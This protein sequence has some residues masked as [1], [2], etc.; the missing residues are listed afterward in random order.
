MIETEQLKPEEDFYIVAASS[1]MAE[2]TRV[3]KQGESFAIFNEHGD[4]EKGGLGEQ[5]LYHQGTRHLSRLRLALG[6]NQPFLL[7]SS[8]GQDNLMLAV[9]M[10]NTDLFDGS[11]IRLPRGTI[12]VLAREFLWKASC[13]QHYLIRNHGL[14]P[15]ATDLSFLFEADFA[16]IFEVRGT[17]RQRRGELHQPV[18]ETDCVVLAYTGLD[19][20]IRR[21]LLHFHPVPTYLG[22][23]RARY[24]LE[25]SSNVKAEILVR[26]S[27]ETGQSKSRVFLSFENALSAIRDSF[28]AIR[29]NESTILTSNEQFNHSINRAATDLQLMVTETEYGPY[30]YAGIPW[31]NTP[32]GRDG[33]ITALQTLW[34]NPTLAKGVLRYLASNQATEVNEDRDA[35]PGKILHET[36]R[37]EMAALNEIPF[38]C[39]YGSVDSTPLFV[40]LAGRYYEHT[41]DRQFMQEIWPNIKGALN[42]IDEYGDRDHDGFVEYYRKTPKGLANQGWKDSFDSVFHAEGRL[43]EG[44]IAL[45][46][47]QCYVHAAK[48]AAARIAADLGEPELAGNLQRQASALRDRF[49]KQFWCEEIDTYALA[50][51]GDKR[52]CQVRTSNAGHA[53]FTGT[54]SPEHA[55][56]LAATLMAEDSFSGWGIRTVSSR[57][58]R[59]NPMSYHNGS[60]W[61]HDN[62]MI[63]YG[64]ARY[65]FTNEALRILAGLFDASLFLDLNRLPE[66]FCGFERRPEEGPTLYPVACAPQAW[67]SGA[68]FLILQGCLG[69]SVNG[70]QRTVRFDHPALPPFL[71]RVEITALPVGQAQIGLSVHEHPGDVGISILSRVGDPEVVIV[72]R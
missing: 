68:L 63:A 22:A 53:L 30:P 38:G 49:L 66:L 64:L 19:Q 61:P 55:T 50:L 42:W 60:V 67:A 16:D 24:S 8:V 65:G 37:G 34:L 29:K 35:E 62:S 20:V 56:R 36:R 40:L 72:K 25:L 52:A 18:V 15:V 28:R 12:H 13:Y 70:A 21:T 32:F 6:D 3:L 69:L 45:C 14:F 46:E 23:R 39:Y 47:V 57:E 48:Q 4:I 2:V 5:G 1:R 26:V 59:Y 51:D 58:I 11:A 43:A 17:R 71:K 10:T 41:G 33:M 27:C 31:F 44:P 54:A 7:N 9:H